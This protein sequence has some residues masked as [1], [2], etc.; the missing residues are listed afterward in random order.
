MLIDHAR[1]SWCTSVQ[2]WGFSGRV[3]V[4]GLDVTNAPAQH[5][6]LTTA[7]GAELQGFRGAT[8]T[9]HMILF[10]FTCARIKGES[11]RR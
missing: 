9:P 3:C 11:E 1:T 10:D 4:Q 8:R 6:R 7:W 5:T 2:N